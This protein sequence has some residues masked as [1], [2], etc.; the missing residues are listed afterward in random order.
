M[1]AAAEDFQTTTVS[2]QTWTGAGAN[3]DIYAAAVDVVVFLEDSRKFVRSATGEQVVSE[4]T[5]FADPADAPL[6]TPDSKVTLPTR[7][8]RVILTKVQVM[9]DPDVDHAEVT[10]S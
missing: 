8:A 5:I 4:S 10:L 1:F 9:G 6:F 3:G 7:S 2:V